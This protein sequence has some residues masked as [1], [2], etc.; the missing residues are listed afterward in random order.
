MLFLFSLFELLILL[1][2]APDYCFVSMSFLYQFSSFYFPASASFCFSFS[3]TLAPTIL[4]APDWGE[5]QE[6]LSNFGAFGFVKRLSI[7]MKSNL[8]A[9][10]NQEEGLSISFN[11]TPLV[12]AP[13]SRS[14]S[15]KD[16]FAHEKS[17]EIYKSQQK[18]IEKNF[19]ASSKF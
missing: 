17:P 1:F 6:K 10:G 13:W 4:A 12:G 2:F 9:F 11:C 18:T 19:L 15:A 16:P 5:R 3:P 8:S 14:S 7:L